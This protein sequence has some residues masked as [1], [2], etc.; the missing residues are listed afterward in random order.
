MNEDPNNKG[1]YMFGLCKIGPKGQ[2]VIPVEARKIFGLKTGDSLMLL[3]DV[4]RGLALVK[5]EVFAPITDEILG[6]K[7]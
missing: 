6:D 7:K 3:G 1:R 5:A 4:N 2:I